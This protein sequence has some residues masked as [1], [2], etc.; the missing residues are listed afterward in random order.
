M[1][2]LQIN[3]FFYR[4]GGAEVVFLDTIKGLRARG[5]EVGEFAMEHPLNLPSDYAAYFASPVPELLATAGLSERWRIFKRLFYSREIE[6]K[7]TALILSAEPEVAHL[8][9]AYHQLSA[10]TFITLR[11]RRV[12]IV[13]TLHDFFPLVPNHSFLRGETLD[14]AAFRKPFACLRYRC[15]SNQWLPSLAGTLEAS[16]YRRRHIWESVARFV[17]PSEF[18]KRTMVAW[19]FPAE[20]LTVIRNPFAP[21]PSPPPLGRA[22][23][24]LGRL[25]AEKGIKIFLEAI[26][27]LRQTPVIIAGTGPLE[28][29][30]RRTIAQSGLT[31]ITLAGHLTGAAWRTV[32]QE[33]RVVVV[34]SVFYENCS[35]AAL[36]ALGAGRLVV[37]SD[38]GGTPELIHDGKTGFLARPEDPADLT[39]AMQAAMALG[40]SEARAVVAAG[41]ALVAA[42]HDPEQYLSALEQV[43]REVGASG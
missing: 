19:G 4:R 39:R 7:L 22:L 41:R 20:K 30:V 17:C 8:H 16:Y 5:H 33:A 42:N 38:R 2:V 40:D 43:Y 9:N 1:R 3:K 21:E 26:K 27:P 35:L 32:M 37:G 29:W 28:Q 36:E 23:V 14:E 25:H 24:Y 18:M 15:I 12:P 13:L 10:S 31:N 34:P 11:Q 6:R